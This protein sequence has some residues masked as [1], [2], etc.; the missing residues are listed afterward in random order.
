MQIITPYLTSVLKI[1]I[2]PCPFTGLQ[3][4][5]TPEEESILFIWRVSRRLLFSFC[6]NLFKLHD[7]RVLFMNEVILLQYYLEHLFTQGR[8]ETVLVIWSKITIDCSWFRQNQAVPI[9]VVIASSSCPA[10][11]TGTQDVMRRLQEFCLLVGDKLFLP[12][13]NS[14]NWI[15]DWQITN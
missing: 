2:N 6:I 4:C 10:P 12:K 11:R 13:T 5:I 7:T 14:R 15:E 8:G 1:E 9:E 3:V